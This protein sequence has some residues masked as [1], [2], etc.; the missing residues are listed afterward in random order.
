MALADGGQASTMVNVGVFRR[1]GGVSW[2]GA[3]PSAPHL[4]QAMLFSEIITLRHLFFN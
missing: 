4:F 3:F 2:W 1:G